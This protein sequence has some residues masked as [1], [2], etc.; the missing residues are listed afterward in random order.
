[1]KDKS[2][3]TLRKIFRGAAIGTAISAVGFNVAVEVAVLKNDFQREGGVKLTPGEIAVAHSVFGD[4]LD[5]RYLRKHYGED[6][7]GIA[8]S[9]VVGSTRHIDFWGPANQAED[10]SKVRGWKL[11][12][13]MHEMTHI[14]QHQNTFTIIQKLLRDCDFYDYKLDKSSDFDDFCI[15]Q[16]GAIVQ[17]YVNQVLYPRSGAVGIRNLH[18]LELARVVEEKFPQARITRRK[19]EAEMLKPPANSNASAPKFNAS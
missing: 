18:D 13:F 11:G 16:Q 2:K 3:G 10:F 8:A 6:K 17:D 19:L 1:M 12:V 9:V 5:T 7:D 4:T 15:E 14:W